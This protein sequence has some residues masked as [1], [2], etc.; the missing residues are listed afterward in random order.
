MDDAMRKFNIRD[1]SN[2]LSSGKFRQKPQSFYA[3]A[4][5]FPGGIVSR[6][7]IHDFPQLWYCIEGNYLHRTPSG[8]HSC[9]QGSLILIPP[10]S[11]D[12][13]QVPGGEGVLLAEIDLS[14]TLFL[15]VPPERYLQTLSHLFL[16][17]YPDGLGYS[18]HNQAL[19]DKESRQAILEMVQ[20]L[21][22]RSVSPV[23]VPADDVLSPMEDFFSLPQFRL[24]DSC[25]EEALSLLETK[26]IPILRAISFIGENY[27]RKITV[28]ELTRVSALCQTNFFRYFKILTGT[29][30]STYLQQLR[31]SYVTFLIGNTDYSFS[32]ISQLCGFNDP[33]HMTNVFTRCTGRPPRVGRPKLQVYYKHQKPDK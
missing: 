11:P 23:K 32:Y 20:T 27:D 14:P 24:P 17:N 15:K 28:E 9:S 5:R 1:I 19:L 21:S 18:F 12:G 26:V 25:A 2:T 4:K 6:L 16:P 22:A 3:A 33:A 30:F 13:F 7:H 10:G 29:S 8:I 31:V